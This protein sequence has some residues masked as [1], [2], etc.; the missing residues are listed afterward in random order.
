M[1][2]ENQNQNNEPATTISKEAEY[3]AGWQR[4]TA[5]YQN[6][7]KEMSRLQSELGKFAAERT[8][9]SLLPAYE[10][11]NKAMLQR[12]DTTAGGEQWQ[13]WSLGLAQVKSELD[14][15]LNLL[16]VTLIDTVQ[17]P[18][19]PSIHEPLLEETQAETVAGLVLKIIEP[20]FKLYEKVLKPA[21]VIVSK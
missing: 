11:L 18:F 17:I 20:G 4:A 6:L 7:Q 5:D 15:I 19:D 8:L 10:N 1:T 16:G 13:Q 9:R 14:R 21:K 3:L 2:E 12:P